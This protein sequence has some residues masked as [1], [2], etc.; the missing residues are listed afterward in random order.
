MVVPVLLKTIE[1]ISHLRIYLPKEMWSEGSQVSV[2]KSMLEI[3]VQFPEGMWL[4]DLDENMHIEGDKFK[5]L[6]GV[7]SPATWHGS[8]F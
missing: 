4:L 2:W 5:A 3:Q 1:A 8:D 7:H 6:V